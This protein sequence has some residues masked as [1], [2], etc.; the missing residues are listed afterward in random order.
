LACAAERLLIRAGVLILAIGPIA[1]R[2]CAARCRASVVRSKSI[3]ACRRSTIT[4][5]HLRSL[6]CRP[7]VATGE[8]ILA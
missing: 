7:A 5:G 4:A 3:A 2:Q 6:R 8:L 1:A